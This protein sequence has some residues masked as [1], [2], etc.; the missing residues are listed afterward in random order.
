MKL[1][2]LFLAVASVVSLSAGAHEDE[3]MP[4]GAPDKV[5]EV[6]FP[7]SCSAAAQKE[8]NRGVAI[9][10][11][12]FYP[13]AGKTFTKVTELDPS[14]A[15]GYWGIAM[16]WWYPLWYPPTKESFMQGK[17]A[18]EKAAVIDGKTE[19]ERA[20]I[21]AIGKFYGDFDQRDHKSRVADYARAMGAVFHNYPD[22]REAAAFYAL[23][24]QA[25]A[26]PN[27]K[28]YANQLK[29]AEILE[30]VFAAQPNHPGAAHYL[31]HAYD[32]PEL[33]PRALGPARRYGRI[34]PS[35]P[36]ALHMP[37]HTFIAVGMWQDSIQSNLA[38]AE[39]A[40]NLG[41]AQEESHSL[42][43]LVYAYLQGAQA[44]AA[45]DILQRLATVKV[46]EKARTLPVDYAQAAVPARFAL[47][48]RRWADAAALTPAP[49]RFPATRALTYYA[50]ALGAAHIGA[51]DEVS[52]AVRELTA[53]RDAL[54]ESKQDY[55]A[56]QVEVQR[57]T[58]QAWLA[59]AHGNSN[60]AV[61]LMRAAADLEDTTYKHPI[62]PGQLLPARELLGDL[63][64]EVNQPAQ[65]LAAYES[66]LKLTPNRFN[67]I[68]G[69]AQAAELSGDRT[70]AAAYYKQLL[71]A[72]EKADT[73]RQEVQRAR[74]FLASN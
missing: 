31:I 42:D 62:T 16:S 7:I 54:L 49:S 57:E 25:T 61:K 22:D 28:T 8:F 23:S 1:H 74:L 58:A 14:C 26:N 2:S 19:R 17:A 39:S 64:L 72:C 45:R 13:E 69:A 40:K 5:G 48:Q 24:L 44:G 68:Y 3:Q 67:G 27:D 15:M 73:D 29:S 46:D 53:V 65:A 32:Y 6:S 66:S 34:A 20:Y 35:I 10:H 56:K 59:W 51:V 41:W 9:L 38:A 18:A 21:A 52:A 37:S 33:A 47:E 12:F 36:H 71:A 63:L 11:S 43:Y 70:K 30:G 60:E 4:T 55:W 50:R